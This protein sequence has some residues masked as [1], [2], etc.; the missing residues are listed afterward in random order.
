TNRDIQGRLGY[1][2]ST[3]SKYTSNNEPGN[4]YRVNPGFTR[5]SPLDEELVDIRRRISK[6]ESDSSHLDEVKEFWVDGSVSEEEYDELKMMH[7]IETLRNNNKM[8]ELED[9]V[10]E[11]ESTIDTLTK[12]LQDLGYN[13]KMFITEKK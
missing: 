6:Q 4:Y 3:V 12:K 9:R 1:S 5:R 13:A 10:E 8:K 2:L 7:T 11:L